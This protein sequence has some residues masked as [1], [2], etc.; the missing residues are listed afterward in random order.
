MLTGFSAGGPNG[1]K[2]EVIDEILYKPVTLDAL[3]G[4]IGRLLHAA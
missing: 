4:T 2:P 3:R 1:A